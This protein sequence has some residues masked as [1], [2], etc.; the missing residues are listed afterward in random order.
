VTVGTAPPGKP[1][2][3]L[4]GPKSLPIDNGAESSAVGRGFVLRG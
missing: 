2:V 3:S 1:I 4:S